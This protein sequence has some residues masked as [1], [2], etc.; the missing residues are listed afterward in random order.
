M[1]ADKAGARACR[2]GRKIEPERAGRGLK[3]ACLPQ[4][5][6]GGGV[7]GV[8]PT[9]NTRSQWCAIDPAELAHYCMLDRAAGRTGAVTINC[10]AEPTAHRDP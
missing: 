1:R 4:R 10:V 7:R 8:P 2:R 3:L 9:N 5:G 6:R